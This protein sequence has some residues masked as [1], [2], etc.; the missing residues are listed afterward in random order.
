MAVMGVMNGMWRQQR[1]DARSQQPVAPRVPRAVCASGSDVPRGVHFA[2]GVRAH[3][4]DLHAWPGERRFPLG[5][6]RKK[7]CVAE[8]SAPREQRTHA[9]DDQENTEW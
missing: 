5:M 2:G 7:N 3:H 9:G 6:E 8:I 1:F 4:R